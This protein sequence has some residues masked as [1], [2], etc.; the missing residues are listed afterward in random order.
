MPL[1]GYATDNNQ[2]EKYDAHATCQVYIFFSIDESEARKIYVIYYLSK[3]Q[4]IHFALDRTH[5]Q[6]PSGYFPL[7]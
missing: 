4:T 7:I 6:G 5:F 2:N 3:M 1:T